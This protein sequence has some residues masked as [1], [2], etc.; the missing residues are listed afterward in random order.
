M[1]KIYA[2][3]LLFLASLLATSA[4]AYDF[5]A[6]CATGQTL[7][8]T[9]T[10]DTLPY[11]VKVVRSIFSVSGDI[12]I[13]ES[14]ENNSIEY[15]VTAIGDSA[16]YGSS[17][18]SVIIPNTVATIGNYAFY[19]SAISSLSLPNSLTSIG[20]YAFYH[21]ANLTS[22][23][24]PETVTSIDRSAFVYCSGLT[25]INF[26][27]TN[28]TNMGEPSYPVF[29]NCSAFSTLNIGDNV[30]NIPAYAFYNCH[31]LS[32]VTIPS[33]VETIG[34]DA[35]KLVRNIVYGG[36][37]EGS[38]WGALTVDGYEEG[39]LVYSDNTKTKITGCV[40]TVTSVEIPSSVTEIGDY[41]FYNCKG[42]TAISLPNTVTSIGER[43]FYNC[44]GLTE[45]SLPNTVTSIGD[46][47]F[48]GCTIPVYNDTWFAYYPGG[49]ATEYTVP[50]GILH[51][52][53]GAFYGYNGGSPSGLTTVSI[54]N[55]VTT[56]G[57]EAFCYCQ[58]LTSL[59]IPESVTNIGDRAF[60]SCSNLATVNYNAINCTIEGLTSS[61]ALFSEALTS[62]T[63]GERVTRI[64]DYA[65]SDC[66]GLTRHLVIPD[67]VTYIGASAFAWCSGITEITL[68]KS[69]DDVGAWAFSGCSSMTTFNYNAENCT[70]FSPGNYWAFNA[71]SSFTILNIG[72]NVKSIPPRAF[73][74]CN[75]TE[76]TIPDSVTYIG[77][78]A[79]M[80][81]RQLA[82]VNYNAINCTVEGISSTRPLFGSALTSLTI[83]EKVKTIPSYAF[84]NCSGLTGTLILPDSLESIGYGAFSGCSGLTGT[85]T[86]PESV[87]SFA[88]A[89]FSGCSGLTSIVFNATNCTEMSSCFT[90]C[91]SITSLTI[92]ENVTRIPDHSFRQLGLTGT[93]AFPASVTSIGRWSFFGCNGLS[94]VVIGNSVT[95]IDEYAF[96]ECSGLTSLTISNSVTSIGNSAFDGCSNLTTVNFNATNCT[97]MGAGTSYAVFDACTSLSTLHIA[98]N[99]TRIPNY[100]FYNCENITDIYVYSSTPPTIESSSY[101]FASAAY[102][103]ATVW[104][105]CPTATIYRNT[106]IWSR[107]TNI[108]NEQTT[109][110][111]IAVQTADANMGDVAGDGSFTCDTEVALTATPNDGY[112]FLSWNDGNEDNPRTIVVGGDSTFVASFR[113]V[114]TI[115][116][117]A[118]VG[119]TISPSGEITVDEDADQSFTI[120]PANCYRLASVLVD[121]VEAIDELVGGVYTFT[122]VTADH[123]IEAIFE[124][125]TYTISVTASEHGTVTH[126]GNEGDAV[127]NC[128]SSQSF[129]ITP[130]TYYRIL[131]VIVDGQDVTSQLVDGVYSFANVTADHT[132]A[133]TFGIITYTIEASANNDEFGSVSG[134][135]TYDAGTEISLTAM[136]NNG[137][138][139]VSWND[140]NTDNPRTLIVTSDSTFVAT[141]VR[142]QFAITAIS[143]DPD[144]GSVMGGETYSEGDTATLTATPSIG[145]CF[146]SWSDG[147]TDNPRMVEVVQD[148]TFVAEFSATV[149]RAVDTTVT[150]Y[151]S[152]DEHTFYVS[153]VYSYI[154]PSDIGCDT[155]VD[156]TLQVLDE[157]KV[158]EISPNPA[159][160]LINISSEDYISM[161]EIYSTAG[162]LVIQKQ[163]DANMAEINVEWLVPGVYFVRLFG[164]SGGQPTVQR[165]VK[166]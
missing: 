152:V 121:G 3:I 1:R 142:S 84:V 51:I 98:E 24:I 155:I 49:D 91:T 23:T 109:I 153:G 136:P 114:H 26:N 158:F 154:I 111:N 2:I 105:P 123:T 67:S 90:D 137:Y 81:C 134:G 32:T 58:S 77:E 28:C 68:G 160:S 145:Y 164:E 17:A 42:V 60:Y 113:A 108:Q 92:G 147:N 143:S 10:S 130:E 159:K 38:P 133:V 83:G 25:T 40:A 78:E 33:S 56:I 102:S 37:A 97:S 166:E 85:L 12:E 118:S 72:E 124:M 122:G 70:S 22:V 4:K 148:S 151:L 5:Y 13:P 76:V 44:T 14:V 116:A 39:S 34:T 129:T 79:F 73:Q 104:T 141:F 161:V 146:I 27:A 35:F 80:N 128:G 156:L 75:F 139:F 19:Y 11:T 41:A 150:S 100:A 89:V 61:T 9:I 52:A 21:C 64:P 53:G 86:I 65:F 144:G 54:P 103:N 57:N 126:E 45:I 36:S 157:P 15:T 115:T 62:L 74:L 88:S 165:F 149:H 82:T 16:F 101:S 29:G 112:R 131:S 47:A 94:E 66:T 55:T 6:D 96:Y 46:Y 163:I 20:A 117:S 48:M 43:A 30:I 106:S 140:A 31:W 18:T 125:L 8:Y 120:A 119:G 93:L 87:T 63:I 7:C 71:C 110:Y 107:F 69:V 162:R 95:N 50:D 127:V 99:V 138:R 132:I 59:T 135:G